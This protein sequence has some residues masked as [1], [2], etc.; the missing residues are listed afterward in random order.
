MWGDMLL[1]NV[2]GP[3]LHS[4]DHIVPH[5]LTVDYTFKLPAWKIYSLENRS[6]RVRAPA[7]IQVS[8]NQTVTSSLT[9]KNL[10]LWGASVINQ[11]IQLGKILL[12]T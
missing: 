11:I 6:S 12:F 4:G 2:Q 10:I 9:C 3:L 5:I 7:G 1:W 8:K